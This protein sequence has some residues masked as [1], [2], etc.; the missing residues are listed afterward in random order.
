[1]GDSLA[2]TRQVTDQRVMHIPEMQKVL[3]WRILGVIW[4][5]SRAD[6]PPELKIVGNCLNRLV[7]VA[8]ATA[9]FFMMDTRTRSHQQL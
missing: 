2:N 6:N 7:F 3:S 8:V 4:R 1:M 9:E 5:K